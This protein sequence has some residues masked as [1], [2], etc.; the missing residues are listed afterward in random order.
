MESKEKR[1]IS[2]CFF[3]PLTLEFDPDKN[4]MSVKSDLDSKTFFDISFVREVFTEDN[5]ISLDDI[6]SLSETINREINEDKFD[7]W[8]YELIHKYL[9]RLTRY[10]SPEGQSKYN[11]RNINIE[12]GNYPSAFNYHHLLLLKKGGKSWANYAK[13]NSKRHRKK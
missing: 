2:S 12:V 5:N 6:D 3:T 8:N 10:I 4:I 11:D 7:I 13:K 1:D 9:Q